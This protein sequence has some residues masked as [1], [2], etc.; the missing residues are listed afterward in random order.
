LV[1]FVI[2]NDFSGNMFGFRFE[3]YN[4]FYDTTDNQPLTANGYGP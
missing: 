1:I 3:E 2:G 4:T